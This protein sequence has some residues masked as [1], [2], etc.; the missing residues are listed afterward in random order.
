[1]IAYYRGVCAAELAA[2]RT[3]TKAG[4]ML[5]VG[6]SQQAVAPYIALVARSLGYQGLTVACINS[7]KNVTVAGDAS[8]IEDLRV[9]VEAERIFA[10]K[11]AV[12]VA[13]HSPHVEAVSQK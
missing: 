12:E 11:L 10:R 4:A 8:Q 2:T 13:Y 1:M 9:L 3:G 5:A 7:P 6:L